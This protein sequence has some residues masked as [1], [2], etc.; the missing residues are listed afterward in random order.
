MGANV[1]RSYQSINSL[2]IDYAGFNFS[3]SLITL[4]TL[5]NGVKHLAIESFK[6]TTKVIQM[7][8]YTSQDLLKSIVQITLLTRVYPFFPHCDIT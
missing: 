5:A 8:G 1:V 2:Y 3:F 6:I 4:Y 7:L